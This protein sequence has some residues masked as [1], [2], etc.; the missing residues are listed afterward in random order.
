MWHTLRYHIHCLLQSLK[1][2]GSTDFRDLRGCL[3]TYVKTQAKK[4]GDG[5][6]SEKKEHS[7]GYVTESKR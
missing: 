2:T 1:K 6:I 7:G 3:I 5:F 4:V